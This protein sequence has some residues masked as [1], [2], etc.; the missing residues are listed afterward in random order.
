MMGESGV[1]DKRV[2]RSREKV[3]TETYRQLARSGIG[4]LSIDEVSRA[5]GVSKT[6]IYRHWPSRS[7]L[8]I[9]A[10]S[11]LSGAPEAPDSGNL[12]D[13]LRAL[14]SY[15]ADQLETA[16]WSSVYPSVLDAA[17]RDSEISVMQQS[18]HQNFMAP[19]VTV[20]A[21]AA[22]R[23]EIAPDRP[24]HELI[25]MLVGPLFFRRWFSKEGI[26]GTFIESLIAAVLR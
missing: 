14:L 20:L 18:L 9:D 10:C 6:T 12:K 19:F 5:S 23:G 3:L 16:N 21:R 15:L 25:A 7:A 4:G 13:D 26:D 11:R 22:D 17:E 8:L 24:H 1:S 2:E